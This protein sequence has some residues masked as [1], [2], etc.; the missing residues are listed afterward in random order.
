MSAPPG[1]RRDDYTGD[2]EPAVG[3]DVLDL[4]PDMLVEGR[5]A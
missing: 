2:L 5:G 4:P 3:G 1:M